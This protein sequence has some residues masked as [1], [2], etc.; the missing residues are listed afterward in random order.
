LSQPFDPDDCGPDLSSID[1]TSSTVASLVE[2][3]LADK[4]AGH[5]RAARRWRVHNTAPPRPGKS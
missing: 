5:K 1:S 3:P 4:P 2:P